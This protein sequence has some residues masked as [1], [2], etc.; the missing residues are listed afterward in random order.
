MQTGVYRDD[1]PVK[2][3]LVC[4]IPPPP[5]RPCCTVLLMLASCGLRSAAPLS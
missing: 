1:I 3:R 5:V 4:V 2:F